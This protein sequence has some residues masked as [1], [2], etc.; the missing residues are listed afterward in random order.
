MSKKKKKKGI[1]QS[2]FYRV[3][4]IVVTVALIAIVIGLIWLNG[5]VGDYE[6][7]LPVHVAE[8]VTRMFE[9]GDYARI[10]DLDT[11]AQELSGGDKAFYVDSLTTLAQGKT[12][13]LEDG[14]STN[15]DVHR[16]NVTLD[17]DTLASFTLVP[18]GQ[19][20]AHGYTL[21]QLDDVTTKVTLREPE[22]EPEPEP[23]TAPEETPAAPES[24]PEPEPVTWKVTVPTGYAVTVD[25][26]ALTREHMTRESVALLPDGFLPEGYASPTMTEYAFVTRNATPYVAVTDPEGKVHNVEENGENALTC[27]Y[28]ENEEYKEK[29]TKGIVALGERLAKYTAK[30]LSRNAILSNTASG[31]PAQTILK[32]SNNTWASP[33]RK[34]T[35]VNPVVS[36]FYMLSSDCLACHLEFTF[37]LTGK[38]GKNYDYPTAYTFCII[39]SGGKAK[40]YNLMFH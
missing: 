3:Y 38:D 29:Y 17:G 5:Y 20:S 25:G 11:A 32:N 31:S 2:R 35:V 30:D 6:R 12:V 16:Y 33:H 26:Q 7:S 24:E 14:Y 15:P 21:W 27:P 13:E 10:Y 34:A 9:Q 36:Q 40:L 4:F 39:K 1:L 23:E 28:P 8:D 37:V 19:K 22:P 18:S